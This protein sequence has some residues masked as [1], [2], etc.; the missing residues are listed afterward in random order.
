MK[1]PNLNTFGRF[2]GILLVVFTFANTGQS[3][4]NVFELMERKDLNIREVEAW[5]DAYFANIGT[6]QGSGFKQY[7]RWLYERKFHLDDFGYFIAAERE[8]RAYYE[9]LRGMGLKSRANMP[10]TELGPQTWNYTSG[11]NPGN[12][13]LTSVAVDPSDHAIIYVSSPGGGIWKST[14][15]GST[16]TTLIDFVN[17][18]W[19]SVFHICIDPNNTT[20]LYAALSSG[21]VLKSSNSGTSWTTTGSGPTNSRQIKVHP[22]DANIVFCAATNGI[23][24][25]TN[26]GTNW[27][28]VHTTTKED[29]EFK[30]GNPDIMYAS[31]SSGTSCVYRSTDN[32]LSWNPVT[33]GN[34]ITHTG[35]TLLAVS[36]DDPAVVY[37]VQASGSLFGRMYKSTDSGVNFITTVVGN[38]SAGTN[39]FGY[40]TNGTG[41][42]GQ[43]TYDMAICV[44]PLEVNEVHIAGIICWKSTNGG[45][46]FLAETAWSYPNSTGYNHADVHALEWVGSNIYSGSDGGIYKSTNNGN[47]WTD[48]SAGLGIR[49]FYRIACSKTNANV[50]TTGAQDNGS[51]FRRSNSTWVDWLGA[52]GMDNI[53]SP[54][55]ADIAIG[56]SQYGSIY[57]TTNAGASRTNL[58]KPSEG[59]WVT[60]LVM[61]H[62]NHDT[63]Y[64]GWTGVWRSS[65]GGSSWTNLSP[66][67]TVKL[68]ALAVSPANTKYIYASQGATLYRTSDG[69]ANWNSV[70]ASASITSIYA[71]KNDPQKIWISCNSTSNRIFV[72]TNMGSTFTNLSTGLPSLSARSVVVDE[73]ASE[74]IYAGMNI[75]VYYRDNINNTWA[76]H[77]TGLP[78]VAINEVEIQKSGN[79]LRVATYGRG[80]WESGLQNIEEICNAP[81]GLTT[82]SIT[83]NSAT[84]NW[85]AVTGAISYR[86]EYKL[87][88]DNTWTLLDAAR[89]S[90]S[91]PLGGLAP[92]TSY[93]W[94]VRSNCSN[95][96]SN[97]SQTNFVTLDIC[98][99][100]TNLNSTTTPNSATLNWNAVSGAISYSIDYKLSTSGTWTSTSGTTSTSIV[101]SGLSEK[102][103]DWR[104]KANC[105]SG[106]GNFVTS[107]FLIHCASAGS[108]TAAGYI[109]NVVLGS[110][111]RVSGSDGGYY[112]GTAI[113]TNLA[114]GSSQTITLSPGYTGTKKPVYFRV[115]I[116]YNRDG[117]FAENNEKAGQKK[118]SNLGNTTISFI[119]PSTAT[120]GKT[121]MRIVMSTVAFGTYCGTYASGETEDYTINITA[122]PTNNDVVTKYI[123]DAILQ[124]NFVNEVHTLGEISVFPNPVNQI[125]QIHYELQEDVEAIGLRIIDGFGRAVGGS[126][127]SGYKGQNTET[128]DIVAL[129]AGTY[130]LQ[131]FLPGG[132]R[133]RVFIISEK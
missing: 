66:G 124:P 50:I 128:L 102:R 49:Q 62:T 43:A 12:G 109:D 89:T 96:N 133:S 29:I 8:D 37:A 68:D 58:S 129:P 77:G 99:D 51:S 47:D 30:P 1:S 42:T 31:G 100:P 84:L 120:I 72:S 11:W 91:F 54:T 23:W 69:G 104:V 35:R 27:T 125:L 107:E 55:N 94:R 65:N 101:I 56:T 40:E 33:S 108:S 6:G 71:S 75:G 5:A 41:T 73:D 90:T 92:S 126:R 32:G 76:E 111:S 80:V 46:S 86:L 98:G 79:K 106:S 10:W 113:S 60:P 18:S 14:N 16:W 119:V 13:R 20:T 121:R 22:T 115:Y 15:S 38:P 67:I 132:Y 28:Q 114:L 36:P 7:Q 118:Y 127:F 9:A 78:L 21:G 63:V 112:D 87:S 116:D 59:N 83:T 44:N 103:Y 88:S 123:G 85:N 131:M 52:D 117:D 39:Y 110:I 97:Y 57:K 48:L 19:M 45:T 130:Y 105:N 2:I 93:D 3:Q 81:T 64:G 24:R 61:H 34:G 95:S 4:S 122:A 53:I 25:S 26:A 70:S 82:T 74:T 17:S